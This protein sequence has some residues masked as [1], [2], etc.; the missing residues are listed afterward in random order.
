MRPINFDAEN[1]GTINVDGRCN[2][3]L[4]LYGSAN[5]PRTANDPQTV[6]QIIPGPQMIHILDRKWFRKKV[7]NG[8]EGGMVWLEK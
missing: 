2:D 1:H 5:D 4:G 7:R 3:K 6:P 8:M